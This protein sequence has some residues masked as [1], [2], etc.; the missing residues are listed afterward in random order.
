MV[1]GPQL[2]SRTCPILLM[3]LETG[4]QTPLGKIESGEGGLDFSPDGTILAAIAMDRHACTLWDTASGK[5][6]R[7]SPFDRG[8]YW[9]LKFAPDGKTLATGNYPSKICIG[10]RQREPCAAPS[11]VSRG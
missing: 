1:Q 8:Q 11:I 5:I 2:G 9:C 3:D 6:L 10:R 4:K 7:K